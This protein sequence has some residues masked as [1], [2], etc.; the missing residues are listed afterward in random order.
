MKDLLNETELSDA[1]TI[2][3]SFDELKKLDFFIDHH[4]NYGKIFFN[5]SINGEPASTNALAYKM[6]LVP[7][8]YNDAGVEPFEILGKVSK[9]VP[10]TIVEFKVPTDKDQYIFSKHNNGYSYTNYV[11]YATLFINQNAEPEPNPDPDPGSGSG[12]GSWNGYDINS[13]PE[14][15]AVIVD[16]VDE[17]SILVPSESSG[18]TD[19]DVR[20]MMCK[21]KIYKTNVLYDLVESKIDGQ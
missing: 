19:N 12:S 11:V 10:D 18:D 4:E 15:D 6:F 21:G 2:N 13:E 17:D 1:C 5:F 8:N 9:T 20:I 16:S 7:G 14:E 3:A